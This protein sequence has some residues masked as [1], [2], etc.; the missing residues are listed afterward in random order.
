MVERVRGTVLT[1]FAFPTL[2]DS[3]EIVQSF[4]VRRSFQRLSAVSSGAV[5][6]VMMLIIGKNSA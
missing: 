2:K 5:A 6:E 4:F 3:A 1:S